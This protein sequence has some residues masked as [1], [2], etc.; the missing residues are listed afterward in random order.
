MSDSGV[1]TEG[2]P[3]FDR[4]KHN[5]LCSELKNLYT[6]I[7]RARKTL[8]FFDEDHVLREPMMRCWQKDGII[9][10][11]QPSPSFQG[12]SFISS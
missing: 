4:E 9:E 3:T 5:P 10:V 12:V 7:T 2:I 6:A 1:S 8:V 11:W